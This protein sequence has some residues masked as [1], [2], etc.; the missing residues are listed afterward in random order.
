MGDDVTTY[1]N[2]GASAA[3]ASTVTTE[4][5]LALRVGDM[6]GD[7]RSLRVHAPLASSVE[8]MG[9]FTNWQPV[10]LAAARDGWWTVAIRI[11]P[12]PHQLNVRASGGPWTVIPGLATI[13]DEFGGTVG[14]LVVP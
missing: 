3:T 1:A 7:R 11:D 13:N 5:V 12:G 10:R 8:I 4:S 6:V 14:V 2:L 9:D